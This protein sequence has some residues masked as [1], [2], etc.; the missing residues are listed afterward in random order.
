MTGPA[1]TGTVNGET[2]RSFPVN[3]VYYNIQFNKVVCTVVIFIFTGNVRKNIMVR[4]RRK[5]KNP[6]A[7]TMDTKFSWIRTFIALGSE[8]ASLF[9]KVGQIRIQKQN[10][11]PVR[12]CDCHNYHIF[13]IYLRELE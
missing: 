12:Q 3:L 8:S 10:V 5:K 1:V 4:I 7:D 6:Y 13:F 2:V 11:D 9:L